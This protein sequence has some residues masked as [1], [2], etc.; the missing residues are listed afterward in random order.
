M[1][2]LDLSVREF[3]QKSSLLATLLWLL[4]VLRALVLLAAMLWRNALALVERCLYTLCQLGLLD[5][6]HSLLLSDSLCDSDGSL[7]ATCALLRHDFF[8]FILGRVIRTQPLP[9][10]SMTIG[11]F[12]E[13][14]HTWPSDINNSTTPFSSSSSP[15][16]LSDCDFAT[17]CTFYTIFNPCFPSSEQADENGL[18]APIFDTGATHCLLPLRRL[19]PDQA[20][21]AKR[22]HLKV[23][24]GT[25]VRALLYNNLIYCK[26]V[27]RPLISVGQLKAM[28]DVRFIWSDSSPL[29]VACSGGLKYILVES[30]VIHHLPVISSHEMTV[31]QTSLLQALCGMLP[32]GL[33]I[34]AA[35]LHYSI[36]LLL[37]SICHQIMLNSLKILR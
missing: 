11:E 13:D 17:A 7:R 2:F 25:S 34:L 35:N 19:T 3:C 4:C 10:T 37:P 36:G 15:H 23:A 29:L 9:D 28:L 26:T 6:C 12:Q 14:A 18:L 1:P 22:I 5:L 20:A 31:I 24:S 30:A 27:S 32:L 8:A 16:S 33:N 21:F